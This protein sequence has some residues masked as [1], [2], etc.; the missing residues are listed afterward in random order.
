[1]KNYNS[2]LRFPST[3]VSPSFIPAYFEPNR[4]AHLFGPYTDRG[5]EAEFGHEGQ[6]VIKD[7]RY[8]TSERCYTLPFEGWDKHDR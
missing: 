8:T 6:H 3:N 1:M 2:K 4:Y 7:V 5:Y